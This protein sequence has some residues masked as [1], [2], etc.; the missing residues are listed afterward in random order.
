MPLATIP[1]M[2]PEAA[3]TPKRLFTRPI[4][5]LCF[6]PDRAW[7]GYSPQEQPAY[8]VSRLV[9]MIMRADI[10]RR[11]MA[12]VKYLGLNTIVSWAALCLINGL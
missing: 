10:Y 11:F 7:F 1:E 9:N 12:L 2:P 6:A 4:P 8:H 3:L 5:P